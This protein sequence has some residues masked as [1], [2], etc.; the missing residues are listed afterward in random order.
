MVAAGG[1]LLER[2]DRSWRTWLLSQL[3]R[4]AV[5]LGRLRGGG[6]A[7]RPSLRAARTRMTRSAR[8]RGARRGAARSALL[9]AQDRRRRGRRARARRRGGGERGQHARSTRCRRGWPPAAPWRPR[10][11]A[12]R[13]SPTLQRVAADATQGH[14]GQFVEAAARELRRL[15]RAS[16]PRAARR[17]GEAG[18]LT[19]REQT[20]AELVASGRSNKQVAAALFLSEKTI[21]H[22]LSRIYAKLGVRSRTELAARIER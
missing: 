8:D 20:I 1:P 19:E 10:A 18:E 4:A 11:S 12:R 17:P 16:R 3:V 6:D 14:A 15:G 22:H 13:P 7:G 5:A 21:E 2:A 9:V